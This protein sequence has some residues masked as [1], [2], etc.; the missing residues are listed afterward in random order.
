[1]RTLR[2]PEPKFR[3]AGGGAAA[4][5]DAVAPMPGVVEKVMVTD[6]DQVR[7]GD[8]LVVIIAMKMEVRDDSRA[9][10]FFYL[11]GKYSIQLDCALHAIMWLFR[12]DIH[13]TSIIS[14]Q[15][16]TSNHNAAVK[17][18]INHSARWLVRRDQWAHYN[19]FEQLLMCRFLVNIILTIVVMESSRCL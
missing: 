4:G 15:V 1:M 6:G 14:I 13:Q 18:N 7:A 10:F 12:N 16:D 2:L 9:V 8:P 3:R 5:G 17:Y 11:V 19:N